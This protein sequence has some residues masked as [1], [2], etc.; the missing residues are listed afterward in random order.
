MGGLDPRG[1]QSVMLRPDLV[2]RVTPPMC[3]MAKTREEVERSHLPRGACGF[4]VEGVRIGRPL[5]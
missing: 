3:T 5:V 1:F 2:S 4:R